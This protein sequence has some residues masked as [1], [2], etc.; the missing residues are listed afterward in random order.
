MLPTTMPSV[1][2][3]A[4]MVDFADRV[5]RFDWERTAL[6]RL[7]DWPQ[8]LRTTVDIVLNSRLPMCLGWGPRLDCLYNEAYA[9]L[10]E[11]EHPHAL[12]R[13]L[14]EHL[15]ESWPVLHPLVARTMAGEPT[16]AENQRFAPNRPGHDDTGTFT[17]A[18]SPVFD[19]A[20]RASGVLCTCIETTRQVLAEK[21]L[22]TVLDSTTDSVIVLDRN[23]R[24]T[25][26]NRRAD[27]LMGKP[28]G[29]SVGV[30]AWEALP[31]EVGGTFYRQYRW[32][33]DHQRPVQFE[34]YLPAIGRWLEIYAYPTQD[35]LS[36]FF[37]DITERH[38]TQEQLQ[39]LAHHDPLTGLAN[40]TRFNQELDEA[41]RDVRTGPQAAVLYLD[42]DH[43]KEVNDTLGHPVGDALLAGIARRLRA[44]VR[45]NDTVAR[46]GGDEFA[47]LQRGLRGRHQ[48]SVLAQRIIDT[49]SAP[50]PI[51]NEMIRT[52]V[53]IGI[54]QAPV[55]GVDAAELFKNADIALYQAKAD[56]RGTYRFFEPA[57]ERRI[58]DRRALKSD[59]SAAIAASQFRLVYQPI[60]NLRTNRLLGFE[61]LLRWNHASRGFIAPSEFIPLAEETGLIVPIG[62]WALGQA[63]AEAA[64]W[65]DGFR[66]AVNLSPCQFLNQDLPDRVARALARSGFPSGRLDLEITESVLLQDS[67]PNLRTLHK[68]RELGIG[69][70]LDDFGT[71][72]SSLSYLQSF[73]F[74]KIKIDRSFIVG[75][76]GREEAQAIAGAVIELGHSLGTVV[77]AEGIETEPQRDWFRSRQCDEGQGYLF[78]RPLPPE[79]IGEWIRR[80]A[81]ALDDGS[82][83]LRPDGDAVGAGPRSVASD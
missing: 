77:V 69:M 80:H 46:L 61:A 37:R 56:G 24:I 19:E 5:W 75:I 20:G 45:E 29:L 47:V 2:P 6:G 70:V 23:W 1:L 18:N 73:P 52:G 40:R 42:L 17:L 79:E 43:F 81:R 35:A 14:R 11:P 62:D 82:Q 25:Y 76:P 36:I 66:L 60:L 10:V 4:G 3:P 15:P 32:A 13:P 55:D 21:R 12:G 8:S 67:E 9:A 51:D 39:Y 59:L 16:F 28:I 38:R 26:M 41:M 72:Y 33:M 83:I 31:G 27:E 53:S 49:L 78:S 44:C 22:S 58:L 34:E 65:P 50:Y 57:M 30:N 68:L 71:G 64:G 63:C 54:V 48:P 74:S 7:A